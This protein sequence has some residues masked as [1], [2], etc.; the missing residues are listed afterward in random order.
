MVMADANWRDAARRAL[1][2]PVAA[3]AMSAF[4]ITLTFTAG[5]ERGLHQKVAFGPESE[6]VAIAVALSESL[7]GLKLGYIGYGSVLTKLREVWNRGAKGP[8]DPLLAVNSSNGDLMNEALR[9]AASLGPQE[10]GYISQR[11]LVTTYYDDM[12]QVDYNKIAYR[13]FGLKIEAGYYLFFTLLGTSALLF[14]IAHRSSPYGLALL[15]CVLFAFYVELHLAVF[16]ISVPTFFGMRHSSA[17]GLVP[18]WHLV[19]L[20]VRRRRMTVTDAL[21]ATLQIAIL[22]LAWRIRAATA[23]M[24]VFIVAA[25][26]L[27]ASVHWRRAQYRSLRALARGIAVWPLVLLVAT[28]ALSIAEW[29]RSLH[30]IYATDDVTPQHYTW[31]SAYLGFHL[32]P[33][34]LPPRVQ[35]MLAKYGGGDAL[36]DFGARDYADRMRILPFTTERA[37]KIPGYHSGITGEI[38]PRFHDILMR[39]AVLEAVQRAPLDATVLY[40]YVKPVAIVRTLATAFPEERTWVWLLLAGGVM[41]CAWLATVGD[42]D[43][44]VG[45][46]ALSGLAV[47]LAALPNLWAYP[48]LHAMIDVILSLV[49]FVP[50]AL[51][52]AAAGGLLAW[53]RRASA[54]S[55]ATVQP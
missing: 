8:H 43:R 29:R 21:A 27:A 26:G 47:G 41:V 19:M 13:L 50:V 30:P 3:L 51:G 12:G 54:G 1:L 33:Q 22:M 9:A 14:V 17:L 42:R 16:S 49:A 39:A 25:A 55:H 7:Y 18:M 11:T 38:K 31:H 46:V 32:A 5:I 4:L 35:E 20:I 37:H 36:G 24:L 48:G 2:R 23:W 28:A 52:A 10:L 45:L 15:M 53:R 34:M 40:L 6:Q 44:L